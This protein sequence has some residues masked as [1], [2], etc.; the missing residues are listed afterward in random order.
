MSDGTSSTKPTPAADAAA[1]AAATPTTPTQTSTPAPAPAP[2]MPDLPDLRETLDP[3]GEVNKS[4]EEFT[5]V[6]DIIDDLET[7]LNEAKTSLFAPNTVRVD[8]EDFIDRLEELKKMLPVQL[9]RASAL[10]RE[11]ERRLE[12]AQMQANAIVASAQSRSADMIK[13]ANEQAQFLAGQE[14][15]TAIARQ[16][17]HAILDQ[18]QAKADH[19]TQGAD[20][21]CTTVMEGLQQQLNKLEHDVQA[22]LNV[23]NERQRTAG[24]NMPHLDSND[25]PED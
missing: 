24:D 20:R 5:T 15:V 22:G 12:S 25:Y 18:A 9:E 17:A 21:Y 19:L 13:E 2:K 10:M 11:A 7:I 1:K 16:K 14:N 3:D 6:Y 8:R 4:R 23:L